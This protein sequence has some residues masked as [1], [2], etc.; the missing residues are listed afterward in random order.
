[1]P[2]NNLGNQHITATQITDFDTALDTLIGIV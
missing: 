2:I 1:M